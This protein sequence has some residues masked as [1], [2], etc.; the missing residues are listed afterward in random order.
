M[1]SREVIV[2]A[3]IELVDAGGASRLTMRALAQ[4]L[5]VTATAIYYYFDSRDDVLEAVIDQVCGSIVAA[6]PDEGPWEGRLQTLLEA[7][8]AEGFAHRSILAL[9]ITEYGKKQ[10]VLRIH[11]A[12]LA[13]L[14]DGGFTTES[15][16]YVKGAVMRFC[17][18]HLISQDVA[19]GLDWRDLPPAEFPLYRS[20]GSVHDSFDTTRAFRLGL[21]ALLRGIA[22]GPLAPTPGA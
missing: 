12:I 17:V 10:P 7:L 1:L 5:G 14:A 11:E 19:P 20:A 9:T 3:G 8:V 6:T 21:D 4:R 2:Q 15:A 13:I 22:N 18:G 16:V